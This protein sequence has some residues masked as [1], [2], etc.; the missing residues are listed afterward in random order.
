MDKKIQQFYLIT[1]KI[2]G[3][4][5]V[6]EQSYLEPMQVIGSKG[7]LIDY[8]FE[9]DSK[10]VLHLHAIIKCKRSPT[11]RSMIIKGFH[12]NCKHI[13]DNPQS[14][15]KVQRYIHK[16]ERK[17]SAQLRHELQNVYAFNEGYI[18]DQDAPVQEER[19]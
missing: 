1:Y 14:L 2:L 10:G 4:K 11:I 16:E 17:A 9:N 5:F 18:E 15:A 7:E 3:T 19:C 13:D 8:N 6:N 12:M